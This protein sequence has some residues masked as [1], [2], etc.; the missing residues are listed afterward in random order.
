MRLLAGFGDRLSVTDAPVPPGG[1]SAAGSWARRRA[2]VERRPPV[3][4]LAVPRS[5]VQG[6]DR[7]NFSFVL[8][9]PRAQSGSRCKLMKWWNAISVTTEKG[10]EMPERCSMLDGK[11]LWTGPELQAA[12]WTLATGL[13]RMASDVKNVDKFRRILGGTE[14]ENLANHTQRQGSRRHIQ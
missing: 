1:R 2:G 7:K 13:L 11:R 4:E 8:H 3:C 5:V 12:S 6:P 9:I 14:T 10:N